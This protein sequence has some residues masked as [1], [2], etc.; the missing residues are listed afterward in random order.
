MDYVEAAT[1]LGEAIAESGEFCRWREN[2][3]AVLADEKAQALLVEFRQVQ[4][5]MVKA[6]GKEDI[7]KEGLEE[8]RDSLLAKQNELNG[9]EVTKAYFDAR[10]GFETMM[11]T[12]NEVIQFYINGRTGDSE[13][14]CSGNCSSCSGCH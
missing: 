2:E 9:Y 14:G 8:I 12:V 3:R 4:E 13:G 6:S 11:K 5:D 1:K 10:R 7:T